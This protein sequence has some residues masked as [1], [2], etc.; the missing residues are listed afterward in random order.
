MFKQKDFAMNIRLEDFIVAFGSDDIPRN[1]DGELDRAKVE[2]AI[3]AAIGTADAYL[4]AVGLP[5]GD[6]KAQASIKLRI[7]DLACYELN[8]D[9]V[10]DL[11]KERKADVIT[12]FG[13]VHASR[14]RGLGAT[15]KRC[16]PCR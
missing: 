14:K 10:T 8:P 3:N 1:P 5:A 2:W 13:D 4:S 6:H 11:I 16:K 12:F 15:N 9:H 7:H